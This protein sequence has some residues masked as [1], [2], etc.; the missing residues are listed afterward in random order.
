M[1]T[2]DPLSVLSFKG[3]GLGGAV[4]GS[5]LKTERSAHNYGKIQIQRS[6]SYPQ[7]G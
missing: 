6:S 1:L 7:R 4:G 3:G 2:A 5:S